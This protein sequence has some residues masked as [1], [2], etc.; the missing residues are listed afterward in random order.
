M[1]YNTEI[2]C[3]GIS[4][5]VGVQHCITP[6]AVRRQGTKVPADF[7]KFVQEQAEEGSREEEYGRCNDDNNEKPAHIFF[8]C[9]K[10]GLGAG[11]KVL[12]AYI[13]KHRLG[14]V[15]ISYP[16][17]NQNSGNKVTMY[18]WTPNWEKVLSFNAV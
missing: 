17:V 1:Y 9:I 7:I 18:M 8:S 5:L 3:C 13:R 15:H 14:R 4:E 11:G 2:E 6:A 10:Q 12:A 16:A